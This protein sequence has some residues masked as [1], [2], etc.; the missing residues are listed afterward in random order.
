MR[1]DMKRQGGYANL[2]LSYQVDVDQLPKEVAQ[3]LMEKIESSGILKLQQSDLPS[4]PAYPDM[5][6]YQLV[7]RDGDEVKS[8]KFNEVNIPTSLRPLLTFLEEIELKQK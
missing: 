7:L 3:K 5:F 1:I 2:P 8:L 4:A 6:V